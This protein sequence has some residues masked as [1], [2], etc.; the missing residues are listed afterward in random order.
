MKSLVLIVLVLTISCKAQSDKQLEP[1]LENIVWISG[2]WKGK[3]FGGITEEI[4][5]EPSGGSMMAAF[6]LIKNGK[7]VFY[8]IEVIR[9][10]N[11]TLILQLKHFNN[12]LKGWETKD[13]TVD[14]PLKEIT[15]DKVVF[16]GMTFEKVNDNEMNIFVDI[17]K[18]DGKVDVVK[19]IYKK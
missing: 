18:D 2:A 5:S 13:E 17:K 12:D 15:K 8:E 4:W 16:E 6:K 19:F 9:E 11:N 10:V 1:K 14:F 3:A 7:V